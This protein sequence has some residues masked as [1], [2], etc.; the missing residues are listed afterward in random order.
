MIQLQKLKAENF[1]DRSLYYATF[2]FQEQAQRDDLHNAVSPVY[3]VG[4][5]D[6]LMRDDKDAVIYNL[7]FKTSRNR[8]LYFEALPRFEKFQRHCAIR[9]LTPSNRANVI[10]STAPSPP[11]WERVEESSRDERHNF[12]TYRANAAVRQQD[13]LAG[14]HL[15]VAL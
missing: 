10:S 15:C 1:K 14:R 4:L 7:Q 13:F 11:A 9:R 3:N 12:P 6:F 5:L 2:A 8:V